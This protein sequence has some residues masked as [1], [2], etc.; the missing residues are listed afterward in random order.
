MASDKLY[1]LMVQYKKT[2]LW[3]KLWDNHLFAIQLSDGQV[4]FISV[5]GR[6]GVSCSVCLYVGEKAFASH[7]YLAINKIQNTNDAYKVLFMVDCLQAFLASK[8]ELIEEEL[9]EANSYSKR[10]NV[11]FRG[12]NG[13]PQ[14]LKYRPNYMP[15]PVKDAADDQHMQEALELCIAISDMKKPE[16]KGIYEITFP[17]DG[18]MP[19]FSPSG[20]LL[21]RI[22]VPDT[23]VAEETYE[24][25]FQDELLM[26]RLK[27]LPHKKTWESVLTRS[28]SPVQEDPQEAPYY[29]MMALMLEPKEPYALPVNMVENFEEHPENLIRKIAD[30]WIEYGSIPNKIK[31]ADTRTKLFFQDI[32]HKLNIKLVVE[33]PLFAL[34]EFE[35]SLQTFLVKDIGIKNIRMDVDFVKY[36]YTG[37]INVPDSYYDLYEHFNTTANELGLNIQTNDQA[38]AI[39][40]ALCCCDFTGR[41]SR[42]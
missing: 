33:S 32:A 39:I 28:Y 34:K 42:P 22:R 1:D 35:D 25:V 11:T 10:H 12:K 41:T 38:K 23:E 9:A 26:T 8:D 40:G 15:W 16:D 18:D 37:R 4:G 21:R 3:T 2:K 36:K 7:R 19:L 24:P 6:V 31:C 30:S 13:Y 17:T 29:P 5:M 27:K 20:E 14:F